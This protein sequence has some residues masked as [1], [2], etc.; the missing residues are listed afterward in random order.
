MRR[1]TT[2]PEN[3]PWALP[4]AQLTVSAGRSQ[5]VDA[6]FPAPSGIGDEVIGVKE[7]DEVHVAGRLDSVVDGLVLTA[8]VDAPVHAECTRCLTPLD[9]RWGVDVT[10]F[11][12][13]DFTAFA[14]DSDDGH[15]AQIVAGE[16]EDGDV[17]PLS[18]DRT[19][20]DLEALLRDTLVGALPLQPLCR[21]GCRG[22]CPQCGT[23]LNEHPD[24]RHEIADIRFAALEEMR[25]R[26]AG[27]NDESED[28]P[29]SAAG[30]DAGGGAETNA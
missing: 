8:H 26:M 4:I 28:D 10:A 27:G 6:R 18:D 25:R 13:Y 3:S 15:E 9:H 23:N 1:S 21:P 12:P 5:D 16:E 20:A 11:F 19:V 7:G 17:Y 30:N 29:G 2:R 22:L 24:H 14:D